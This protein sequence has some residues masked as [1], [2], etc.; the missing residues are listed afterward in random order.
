[1]VALLQF[2]LKFVLNKVK[3]KVHNSGETVAFLVFVN[4]KE[5]QAFSSEK[6]TVWPTY[7][8]F[9]ES[10]GVGGDER[11]L[12]FVVSPY[13]IFGRANTLLKIMAHSTRLL[14]WCFH[15]ILTSFY[16]LFLLVI[17]LQE[18]FSF[19]NCLGRLLRCWNVCQHNSQRSACKQDI[20][21]KIMVYHLFTAT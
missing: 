3:Y 7:E 17:I 18:C 15:G 16:C 1:M 5:L 13:I 2:D 21:W 8:N 6:V 19:F 20:A 9:S 12:R 10:A 11:S 4:S 14:R